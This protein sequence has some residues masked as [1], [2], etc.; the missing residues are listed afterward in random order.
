MSCGSDVIIHTVDPDADRR[1]I[2]VNK[3]FKAVAFVV[4]YNT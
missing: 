1:L 2:Q 3:L 4:A